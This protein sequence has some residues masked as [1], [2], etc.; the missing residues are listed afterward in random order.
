MSLL[1]NTSLMLVTTGLRLVAGFVTFV[2][3]ARHLGASDFGLLMYW[4]TVA[5]LAALV[6]GFGTGPYMLK[7]IGAHPQDCRKIVGG[8]GALKIVLA[9]VVGLI[10]A[11]FYPLMGNAVLIYWLLLA[12]AVADAT[13][14]YIF[15]A[16]RG[17]GDYATEAW[18][19]SIMAIVHLGLI[20][21]ALWLGADIM[22]IAATFMISRSL[23]T[24]G[25][26]TLY[27]K[28]Y[29]H[30]G[31]KDQWRQWLPMLVRN[32]AYAADA[33]LTNLYS[34]LDT[35]LLKHLGGAEALG[36]YQA[37]MRLMQGLNN[38]A[39]VLSNVYLPKLSSEIANRTDHGRTARLLYL[40]LVGFGFIVALVFSLASHDI[41]RIVYGT[42]F[43]PLEPLLPWFGVL[44]L[45]RLFA[46]HF[47]ILLTASGQQG[48]RARSIA[49][50]VLVLLASSFLLI[51]S[52]GALGMVAS[53]TLATSALALIYF[54]RTIS[55][56]A[57]H[58]WNTGQIATSIAGFTVIL[59][60]MLRATQMISKP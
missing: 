22:G 57:N 49:V 14:E 38:I 16:F 30:F 5:A 6:V 54:W 8:V 33:F 45:F 28:R 50:C 59:A 37:G 51:P 39:P 40:Q 35:I 52:W 3:V 55:T 44:L 21:A 34:Q 27:V 12:T 58:R 15:C 43:A 26:G 13:T 23:A 29:G 2:V 32:K 47:G 4:M 18:F 24:I 46:S 10:S 48:S 17:M 11:L 53:S 9:A 25:A 1:K 7:E 56:H 41:V 19:S 42:A 31:I 36:I 20:Y 60:L